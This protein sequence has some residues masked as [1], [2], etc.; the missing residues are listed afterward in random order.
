MTALGATEREAGDPAAGVTWV[1]TYG[2]RASRPEARPELSVLVFAYDEADN[3]GPVLGEVLDWLAAHGP[4]AELVF[5]DDGSRDATAE[6]AARAL[7]AADPRLGGVVLRHATNRGIG[8]AL[9]T[10]AR[11]SRGRCL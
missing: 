8:A 4:T 1:G 3:I 5:V 10:G 9:K 7:A 6:A 2:A 11:A